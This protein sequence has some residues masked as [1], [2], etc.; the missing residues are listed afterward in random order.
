MIAI[1]DHIYQHTRVK[2]QISPNTLIIPRWGTINSLGETEVELLDER[3]N[4]P[5][6]IA[7]D[8]ERLLALDD[9]DFTAAGVRTPRELG[10]WYEHARDGS[11][12]SFRIVSCYRSMIWSE[13]RWQEVDRARSAVRV[14]DVRN[15]VMVLESERESQMAAL[16]VADVM[17]PIEGLNVYPLGYPK[18]RFKWPD[19]AKRGAVVVF[20]YADQPRAV[21]VADF[22]R[23]CAV[24]HLV[25][26]DD[27]RTEL[28]R[29][30]ECVDC[31]EQKLR[32]SQNEKPLGLD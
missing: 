5:S 8:R 31:A 7:I 22:E 6:W 24:Q 11:I 1:L 30:F 13:N 9:E 20:S 25:E 29:R 28:R 26:L 12:V 4:P 16:G 14:H 17:V 21:V 15:G 18:R 10:R 27:A 19:D 2:L 23:R 3:G 32:E